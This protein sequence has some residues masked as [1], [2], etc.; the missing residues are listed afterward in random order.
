M[1]GFDHLPPGVV[2]FAITREQ[3]AALIGVSVTKF[4]ELV[5]DGRMPQPREIDRRVLWDSEEVRAAWR[6]IPKRGSVGRKN[7]W[8]GE[9]A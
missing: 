1:S 9:A 3:A 7:S 4:E 6:L 8:T 5:G 2:P